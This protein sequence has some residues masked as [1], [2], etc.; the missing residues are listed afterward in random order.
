M[1]ERTRDRELVSVKLDDPA[2]MLWHGEPVVMGKERIGYV[3]SGGYGHHLGA[4]VGLAW[5][6][7]ALA[8]DLP[9]VGRG[10]RHEGA[11]DDQPRAVL[12]PQGRP[13][14]RLTS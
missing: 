14:A 7:G 6:H 11:R 10:P 12:R 2:P 5:V 8:A 3:T 13:P 1:K 4:A 9:G